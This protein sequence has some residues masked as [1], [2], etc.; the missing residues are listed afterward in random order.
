MNAQIHTSAA[1]CRARSSH[2][3]F[4]TFRSFDVYSVHFRSPKLT[5]L[6]VRA[7]FSGPPRRSA[8]CA[9]GEAAASLG[10]GACTCTLQK[11]CST[12]YGFLVESIMRMLFLA[13]FDAA[14]FFCL[15]ICIGRFEHLGVVRTEYSNIEGA[16]RLMFSQS[17]SAARRSSC[18]TPME[19]LNWV[20][21]HFTPV[22]RTII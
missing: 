20:Y 1:A 8:M 13:L 4:K 7:S 19:V 14:I 15:K 2:R 16:A 22:P 10:P 9:G 3:F 5:P 11:S 21:K 18:N 12:V 17:C 6:Q